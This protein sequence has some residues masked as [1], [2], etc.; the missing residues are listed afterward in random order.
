MR[1]AVSILVGFL[2]IAAGAAHAQSS[3]RP[4][5]PVRPVLLAEAE[6]TS[7]AMSAA[8]PEVS[9]QADIYLLRAH[10]HERVRAGSN[11]C[12]CLVSRD[13]HEGSLYP[14]CFDPEGA[15]TVMQQEIFEVR[16]RM[17]GN[18]EDEIGREVA[19]GYTSGT[20]RRPSRAS[21]AYMMSPRQVLF[22]SAMRDGRRIGA[23]HPHVMISM[24]GATGEQFGLAKNSSVEFMSID[25]SGEPG[26]Q[27]VVMV[28]RWS[29]ST[30]AP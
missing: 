21:V 17:E 27:L 10:G 1:R 12:A 9:A 3:A 8:P 24:P 25:R 22:S 7:L 4:D 20:L 30:Q 23:W 18:N 2:F 29:D 26:A 6:E 13:L 5:Y 16:L 28:P 11:G 14:I 15:R 19:A